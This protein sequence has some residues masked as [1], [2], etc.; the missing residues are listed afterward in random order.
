MTAAA[1]AG[2]LVAALSTNP[3]AAANEVSSVPADEPE[4][5]VRAAICKAR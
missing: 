3:F 4:C 2:R 5:Q 1:E